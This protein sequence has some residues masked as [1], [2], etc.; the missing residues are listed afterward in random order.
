MS[1]SSN[2]VL[3]VGDEKIYLLSDYANNLRFEEVF[4]S[5]SSHTKMRGLPS[6]LYRNDD[7]TLV[8][9]F[10]PDGTLVASRFVFISIEDGTTRTGG[11]GPRLQ[12][13]VLQEKS[14]GGRR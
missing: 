6:R 4:D 14:P 1:F 7:K 8:A 13:C 12:V 2:Y 5:A 3:E 11:T 10:N 9:E